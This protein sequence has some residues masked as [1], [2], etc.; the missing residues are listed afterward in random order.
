MLSLPTSGTIGNS[1]QATLSAGSKA[2]TWRFSVGIP[3]TPVDTFDNIPGTG[4]AFWV[5]LA[6]AINTGLSN[7]RGPSNRRHPLY[8]LRFADQLPT[9]I[10]ASRI[11]LNA[12]QVIGRISPLDPACIR[13]YAGS[14]HLHTA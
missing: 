1:I 2:A 13:V 3:G 10:N 11:G 9:D 8:G 7:A 12:R 6:A 4:N 5:N 14:V